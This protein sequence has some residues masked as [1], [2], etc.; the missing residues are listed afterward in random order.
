MSYINDII[1]TC[2]S[3][4]MSYTDKF[5]AWLLPV[6]CG[7]ALGEYKINDQTNASR[8]QPDVV[9]DVKEKDFD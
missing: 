7:N 5:L 4:A 2:S 9:V 3:E 6:T 1:F 8:V